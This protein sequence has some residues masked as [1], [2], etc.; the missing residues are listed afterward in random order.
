MASLSVLRTIASGLDHPEGI[1]TGPTGE[2]YAGGEA[3]QIYHLDQ[4]SVTGREIANT[5]GFVLGLCLDGDGVLY[6][7]DAGVH[8][9]LQIHPGTGEIRTYCKSAAGTPLEAPNWAAFAD[10]GS[11]FFTDSGT[12]SVDIVNG[13]LIRVPPGG[14][15]GEIVELRPMHLPNGLCAGADGALYVLE[16]LSPR[17][18]VVRDND[19]ET[20]V[21]F[22]G[23]S[24]DGVALCADG[25][26]LIACYY[27]FRLLYV[28]PAGAGFE[29]ILDDPT[30]IHIPMPTNVSFFGPELRSVAIASLGGM[31]IKAADLGIAGAPLKYPSFNGWT[32]R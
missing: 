15:D 31:S 24:P 20:L 8:A 5:G 30:G 12:E 18:S 28:P 13:R 9:V 4:E 1:A 14:G 2:L 3:G 29:V 19:I 11:L 21:E 26:F 6:V 17:L 10:D 7:C 27:P 22:P 16:T 23:H 32:A 25:G